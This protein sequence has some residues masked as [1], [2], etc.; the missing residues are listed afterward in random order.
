MSE[1]EEHL[2]MAGTTISSSFL[3]LVPGL[4]IVGNAPALPDDSIGFVV[5][6]YKRLGP[7]FRVRPLDDIGGAS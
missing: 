4:P 7:I 1:T 2:S 6:Q 3:P 5:A